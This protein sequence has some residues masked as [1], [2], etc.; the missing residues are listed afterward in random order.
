MGEPRSNHKRL[1]AK[2]WRA[3]RRCGALTE[4]KPSDIAHGRGNYCSRAHYA[5]ARR[6]QGAAAFWSHI[7]RGSPEVCWP[8]VG[9]G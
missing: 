9:R 1:S 7:K 8:W 5:E 4:W 3:C 6:D 2:I